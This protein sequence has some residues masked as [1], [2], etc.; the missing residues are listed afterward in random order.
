MKLLTLSIIVLCFISCKEELKEVEHGEG[1]VPKHPIKN[2][3]HKIH[4]GIKGIDCAYCHSSEQKRLSAPQE[5]VCYKCHKDA[6]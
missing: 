1:Y 6:E 2:F 4:N 3:S 5:N